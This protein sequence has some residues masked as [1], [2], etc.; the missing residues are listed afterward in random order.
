MVLGEG[1]FGKVKLGTNIFT[2]DKVR[3]PPQLIHFKVAI[4]FIQQAKTEKNKE[5]I[6]RERN[7]LLKLNHPHIVKLLKVVDD[8]A[9]QEQYMVSTHIGLF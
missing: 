6:E 4:K 2:G 5:K 9:R 7:I 1:S 3:S 8:A